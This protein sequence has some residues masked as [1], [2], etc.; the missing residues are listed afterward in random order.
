M[1][2]VSRIFRIIMK[3]STDSVPFFNEVQK[4]YITDVAR[5][6][7]PIKYGIICLNLRISQKEVTFSPH[8]GHSCDC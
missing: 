7:V 3:I 6:G 2:A 4:P 8:R 5:K 1:I